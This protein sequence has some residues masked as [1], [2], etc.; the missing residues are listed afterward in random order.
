MSGGVD[1]S[2][3]LELLREQGHD[4]VGLTLRV[5][6]CDAPTPEAARLCC[7]RRDI[8]DARTLALSRGI[9]HYVCDGLDLFEERVITPFLDAYEKGWTPNPCVE[10][11]RHAK[12]PALLARARALGCEKLATG[13]YAR[14]EQAADGRW[15]LRRAL[16]AEKDQ[17]YFLYRLTQE[18][19][20]GLLFPLGDLTK[21]RVREIARDRRLSAAGKPESMEVCF[22]EGGDYRE[23]VKRRRPRAF[24]PGPIVDLAGREVGRHEG[25][26]GY[27]VGQRRGLGLSGGPWFVVE[28]RPETATVVVGK[29]E[30]SLQSS[31]RVSQAHWAA[32]PG[33]PAAREAVVKVR[34]RGSEEPA[35]LHPEGGGTVRVELSRPIASV[36]P[37]QSA[38]FYDGDLV[39]GG[40]II[41]K[42]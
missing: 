37:G 24:E 30:E 35:T 21:A 6:P 29:G 19:L 12:I 2:T 39:A 25:V 33:L 13:H 31:F 36:T 4:L 15:R 10:C 18:L 32:W 17:S 26:A 41:L 28:L 23:F 9:P 20:S 34:H 7:T 14:V 16:D 8:E 27:T 40:G 22:V 42:S 5:I 1:S 38:V 3:T 11:N